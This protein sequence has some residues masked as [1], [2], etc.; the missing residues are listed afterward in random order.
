MI[1]LG[2]LLLSNNINLTIIACLENMK[3][4]SFASFGGSGNSAIFLFTDWFISR[5]GQ[6]RKLVRKSANPQLRT[7][8]KSCGHADLRTLAV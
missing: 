1:W 2:T 8:E 7:N 4:G 6:V 3:C 5:A